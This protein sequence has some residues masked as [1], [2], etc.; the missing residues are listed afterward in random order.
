MVHVV[1][2]SLFLSVLFMS[3]FES[4][5]D[6]LV[7]G[8]EYLTGLRVSVLSDKWSVPVLDV[9]YAI[10]INYAYRKALGPGH[11]QIGW[12]QGLVAVVVMGSGGGSTVAVLRGE[13]LGILQS[14]EFWAI[15]GFVVHNIVSSCDDPRLILCFQ[16]NLLV[17]LF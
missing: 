3:A 5:T 2:P 1:F 4:L 16:T 14:N 8:I 15:Y 10:L 12:G 17:V 11:S 6:Q 9:L 13:P 7:Y